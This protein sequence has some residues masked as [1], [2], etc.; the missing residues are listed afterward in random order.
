MNGMNNG[1]IA[2]SERDYKEFGCAGCGGRKAVI[3]DIGVEGIVINICKEPD[4]GKIT[5]TLSEG[6]ERTPVKIGASVLELQPHPR[7]PQKKSF[8]AKIIGKSGD[9]SQ[10]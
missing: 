8:F 7:R 9:S 4:C 5:V 3:P 10:T 2:V 6:M 1:I